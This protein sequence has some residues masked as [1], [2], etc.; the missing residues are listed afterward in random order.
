MAPA[1]E[2]VVPRPAS[3]NA[4]R[5]V[6]PTAL[7]KTVQGLIEDGARRVVVSTTRAEP[8]LEISLVAPTLTIV[9][10]VLAAVDAIATRADGDL[11]VDTLPALRRSYRGSSNW[12]TRAR[13]RT[14]P[15]RIEQ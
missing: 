14:P 10:R 3:A 9:V 7:M 4:G 5:R 11:I 6:S 12:I 15:S 13:Q 1:L 8:M 2:L